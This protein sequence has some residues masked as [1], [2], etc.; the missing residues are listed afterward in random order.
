[1][2]KNRVEEKR[3]RGD[4]SRMSKGEGVKWKRKEGRK[5]GEKERRRGEER[6]KGEEESRRGEERWRRR[7]EGRRRGGE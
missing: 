3:K 5:R 2:E 7:D 1:M 4:V 6:R